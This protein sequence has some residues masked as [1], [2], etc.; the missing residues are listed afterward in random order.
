MVENKLVSPAG[1]WDGDPRH[2]EAFTGI[3][4]KVAFAKLLEVLGK[5]ANEVNQLLWTTYH[6][7]QVWYPF[8][9]IGFCSLAGIVT[10]SQVSK[11][12]KDMNV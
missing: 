10:F 11:R 6:P 7:Y 2:L 3:E 1:A 5:D 4:R 8:V 9:I 12:W